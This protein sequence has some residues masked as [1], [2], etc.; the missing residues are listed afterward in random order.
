MGLSD[1]FGNTKLPVYVLNVTYPLIPDEV[2]EFC[3]GKRAVLIVEEGQPEFIE[4]ELNTILRRADLQTRLVGKE[5]LPA[6]RRIYGADGQGRIVE[7]PR[8]VGRDAVRRDA[9]RRTCRSWRKRC[10]SAPP[11]SAPA[12]RSG[13]CS[14]R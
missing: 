2:R 4:H 1:S 12:A 3:A 8:T 13:R 10:P 5:V 6:C 7:I 14:P 11:A 9:G